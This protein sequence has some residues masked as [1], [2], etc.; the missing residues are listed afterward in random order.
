MLPQYISIP[1]LPSGLIL[2]EW[3]FAVIIPC[4]R[5]NLITN[6][7]FELGTTGWAALGGAA[8]SRV[9]TQQYAGGASLEITTSV[10]SGGYASVT[11]TAATTYAISCR[12]KGAAG[13]RVALQL[14]DASGNTTLAETWTVCSGRWQR[15][16]LFYTP[17][18]TTTY[19]IV[20]ADKLAGSTFWLDAVQLESCA[21]GILEATTYIDGDQLGLTANEVPPAY[22]WNGSPHA[23]TS[24]RSGR[25]R[26][27]GRMIRF[28]SLGLLLSAVIG[29]GLPPPQ[30]VGVSYALLDGGQDDYTRTPERQFTIMARASAGDVATLR[31]TRAALAAALDRDS[32]AL[33]QQLRMLV[34]RETCGAVTS[35]LARLDCKYVSGLAGNETAAPGEDLPLTFVQYLPYMLDDGEQAASLSSQTLLLNA[36]GALLRRPNGSWSALGTGASGGAVFA[37]TQGNDGRIYIGGAF[38]SFGGLANTRGIVAFDPTTNTLSALGT[39]ATTGSVL[40]LAVAPNGDIWAVG[41][42]TDMGGVVGAS[43]VARWDGSAWHTVG[44]PTVVAGAFPIQVTFGNDGSF[45]YCTGSLVRKWDGAAWS[46]IGTAGGG[47]GVLNAQRAPNGDIIVIGPFLSMSGTPAQYFARWDGSAWHA[48]N[49]TPPG[50][51]LTIAF[52]AAGIL[53]AGGSGASSNL[54]SYNGT[55]WTEIG[56]IGTGGTTL[57][58][59]AAL[60]NAR[61]LYVA[62]TFVSANGVSLPE[63]FGFWNGSALVGADA[64]LPGT[65]T[66]YAVS[67]LRDGSVLLGYTTSGAATVAA[68]TTVTNTVPGDVGAGRVYPTIVF[69]G[70]S[71]GAARLYQL[72]NVTTGRAL[73]FDL[74]LNAGESAVLTLNPRQL[75]FVSSWRGD[76]MGSILSGSNEADFFV[77]PGPNVFSLFAADSSITAII[78]WRRAFAHMDAL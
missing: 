30:N 74:T 25:T 75:A 42:F 53:Y 37:A 73:Y 15:L 66:I 29:L 59:I 44:V 3:Q 76:I 56:A 40:G 70:P 48:L 72:V 57:W 32:S 71:T 14:R 35:E 11:L 49:G 6:P 58:S 68:T 77:Q 16:E 39:G 78:R 36:N 2:D 51:P 45:Y 64:D 34:W 18:T 8:I 23:S 26:A 67:A 17:P 22:Y 31:A 38:T 52:D 27:G 4:A 9:T 63:R 33:Q 20:A 13:K 55:A 7:S 28:A 24:V 12:V 47:L 62:G 10:G 69:S 19:L 54:W 46:T 61:G 41:P 5:T 43:D 21:D 50:I 65:P 1:P 60:A